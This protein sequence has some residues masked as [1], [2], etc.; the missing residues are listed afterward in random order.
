MI[1]DKLLKVFNYDYIS[2]RVGLFFLPSAFPIASLFI[3]IAL[4]SQT[5]KRKDSFLKDKFNKTLIFIS[6]L[7]IISCLIQ[8]LFNIYI[9]DYEIENYLTWIGLFNWIPFFWLFWSAQEFLKTKSDR[10]ILSLILTLSTIP[11]IL[12]GIAQNYFDLVGPI[13]N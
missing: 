12:S 10:N 13:I 2:F 8:N 4:I 11:V 1:K 9:K 5:F 7:M 6:V 3:I